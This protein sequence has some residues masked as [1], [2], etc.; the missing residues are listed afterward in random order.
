MEKSYELYA[1]PFLRFG[2]QQL[3]K[4]VRAPSYYPIDYDLGHGDLGPL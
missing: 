3:E 1:M 4:L 2:I